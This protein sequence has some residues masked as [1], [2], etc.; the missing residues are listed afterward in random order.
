MTSH[1]FLTP[2]PQV[3]DLSSTDKGELVDK[4]VQ[5]TF[6]DEFRMVVLPG[7]PGITRL[8][9]FNT[10]VPQ[11][12]PGN[13]RQL[14]LPQRFRDWSVKMTID[15]DRFLGRPNRDEPFIADPTQAVLV[16]GFTK[17]YGPPVFITVVMQAL[18]GQT[19]PTSAD[20]PIP[21]A[22][23]GRDAVVVE[24]PISIR[25]LQTFVHG[26]QVAVAL[27]HRADVWDWP[28]H[29]YG[30]QTFDFSRWGRSSLPLW[31]GWGRGTERSV[32][33]EDE[34]CF[35]EGCLKFGP[36]DNAIPW[37]Q[38]R[39]LSDGSLFYLV[40]CLSVRSEVAG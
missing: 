30:V 37:G 10:L 29:Y 27:T 4:N 7:K 33:F 20:A 2:L 36:G 13:L 26:T 8:T 9:V 32:L 39:S 22:D 18:I 19:H 11:D 24:I 12:N 1:T 5:V 40:S 15:H 23:W 35:K 31:H 17:A 14:G 38:L 16:L 25:G 21:W 3:L 6:L 34:G 28:G